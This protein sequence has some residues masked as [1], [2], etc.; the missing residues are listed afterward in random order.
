MYEVSYQAAQ[1]H[2]YVRKKKKIIIYSLE[3]HENYTVT[4]KNTQRGQARVS[5]MMGKKCSLKY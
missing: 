3:V 5:S 4:G 1:C 2:F